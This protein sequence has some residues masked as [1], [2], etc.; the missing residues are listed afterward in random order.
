MS[1]KEY[2]PTSNISNIQD[3]INII[4][5]Y[6]INDI[7]KNVKI[8]KSLYRDEHIKNAAQCT[9][10]NLYYWQIEKELFK[11][12]INSPDI[13]YQTYDTKGAGGQMVCR[14]CDPEAFKKQ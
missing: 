3:L 12:N 7:K 14:L 4:F 2:K 8:W 11:I 5:A 6:D 1:G 10:C 9:K 13:F